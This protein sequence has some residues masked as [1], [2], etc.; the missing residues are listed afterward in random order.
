MVAFISL[1]ELQNEN[2]KMQIAKLP[3]AFAVTTDLGIILVN[4]LTSCKSPGRF[5]ARGVK[6]DEK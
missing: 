6:D 2:I 5:E 1:T 3:F 4:S